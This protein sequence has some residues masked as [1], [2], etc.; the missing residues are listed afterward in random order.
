MF[1]EQNSIKTDDN[2]FLSFITKPKQRNKILAKKN[3]HFRGLNIVQKW[4][5]DKV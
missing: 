3:V 2:V 5:E 1:K 4:E